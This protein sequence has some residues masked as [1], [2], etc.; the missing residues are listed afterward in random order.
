MNSV[1]DALS[2]LTASIAESRLKKREKQRV[3][4]IVGQVSTHLVLLVRR[5]FV[6]KYAPF[7]NGVYRNYPLYQSKSQRT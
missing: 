1:D 4:D 7:H 3:A 5:R 2:A 6:D